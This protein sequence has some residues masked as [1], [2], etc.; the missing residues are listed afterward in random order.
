MYA[1]QCSAVLYCAKLWLLKTRAGLPINWSEE[2]V[3]MSSFRVIAVCLLSCLAIV[4]G[5]YTRLSL[6]NF[7]SVLRLLFVDREGAL[8][9]ITMLEFGDQ[10][11][12]E[13]ITDDEMYAP[14][15]YYEFS[16]PY[17]RPY[18]EVFKEGYQTLAE[19]D[20]ALREEKLKALPAK[21]YFEHLG[22]TH[23][24]IDYNGDN[25]ALQLD[26]RQDLTEILVD[27]TTNIPI[28][29]DVITNIGFTEHVGE[30]TTNIEEFLYS[31]YLIFQNLHNVGSNGTLLYHLVPS[32]SPIHW[33]RHGFCGYSPEFFKQLELKNNYNP[34]LGPLYY[35][36]THETLA[37]YTTPM[38]EVGSSPVPF[39]SFEDFKQL[40]LYLKIH[41]HNPNI[42]RFNF[43]HD[44]KNYEYAVDKTKLS[45]EDV[46]VDM[47]NKHVGVEGQDVN[48]CVELVL[49]SLI[50]IYEAN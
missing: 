40:P 47:C 31:Q 15:K 2:V 14:F 37:A 24:S 13:M 29:F 16:M 23:V 27:P 26:V 34:I 48:E 6:E 41:Q 1:A 25:E 28:H 44:G 33:Q 17:Q 49:P 35:T 43:H 50:S 39:M 20:R 9:P 38:V 45:P 11:M 10:V 32:H 18:G 3:P 7:H 22:F 21:K 30:D 4:Q 46:T 36:N 8:Q 5:G 12:A 19:R 42:I